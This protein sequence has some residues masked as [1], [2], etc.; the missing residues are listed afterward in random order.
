MLLFSDDQ[1]TLTNTEENMQEAAY[2]SN[3]KITKCGVTKSAQKTKL[4]AFKGRYPVRSKIVIENKIIEKVNSFNYL[5]NLISY[6]REV[7]T[8]SKLN[9]YL[10]IT[11]IINNTFRPRK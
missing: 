7:D 5:G 9:N 1:I 8:G 2:K 11:G 4:M 3:K 10:K 6:E